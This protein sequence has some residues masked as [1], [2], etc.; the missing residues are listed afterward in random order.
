M[1]QIIYSITEIRQFKKPSKFEVK[2]ELWI[3]HIFHISTKYYTSE[4]NTIEE[5]KEY[6]DWLME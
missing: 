1:K 4:F 6:R 3:L 2:S 5:A